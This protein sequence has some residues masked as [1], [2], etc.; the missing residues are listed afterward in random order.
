MYAKDVCRLY[1]R[2]AR[3][4]GCEMIVTVEEQLSG[5]AIEMPA[6]LVVLMVGMEPREDSKQVARS[7]NIS[8]DKAGWF[9]ESH[10]S[11]IRWPRPR[12]ESISPGACQ[13]PKDIPESVI[14]GRAAAG[15]ILAKVAQGEIKRRMPLRGGP[16]ESCAPDAAPAFR[17]AHTGPSRST[18]RSG[19][20]ASSARS[21]RP[22]LLRAGCPAG[23]IKVATPPTNRSSPRSKAYSDRGP[24]A[25]V[26]RD[27]RAPGRFRVAGSGGVAPCRHGTYTPR[28][29]RNNPSESRP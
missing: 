12:T 18:S 27:G 29:A 3:G 26:S 7:V 24:G 14:Q 15:A 4:D 10:P 11:S 16:G 17:S 21:A 25:R 2:A 19:S 23:A 9:I 20:A 28:R 22:R 6:D 8:R 1:A 5:E 13:F